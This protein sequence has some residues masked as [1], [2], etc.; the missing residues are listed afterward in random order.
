MIPDTVPSQ[1]LKDEIDAMLT[2][3]NNPAAIAAVSDHSFLRE[4]QRRQFATM[5]YKPG[6]RKVYYCGYDRDGIDPKRDE[7]EILINHPEIERE[8]LIKFYKDLHGR[9]AHTAE[10]AALEELKRIKFIQMTGFI[11]RL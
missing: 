7:I 2:C 4:S 8:W 5:V 9:V 6:D 1:T 10:K 11:P 3:V